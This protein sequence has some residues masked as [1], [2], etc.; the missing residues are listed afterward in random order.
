MALLLEEGTDKL[1][2]SGISP[3]PDDTGKDGNGVQGLVFAKGLETREKNFEAAPTDTVESQ[4]PRG[5]AQ[6]LAADGRGGKKK[7]RGSGKEERRGGK[8]EGRGGK[9]VTVREVEKSL[10]EKAEKKKRVKRHASEK[11]VQDDSVKGKRARREAQQPAAQ[12]V[13]AVDDCSA[14]PCE[15]WVRAVGNC[16]L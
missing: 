11:R 5:S 4:L 8:E 13:D 15:S 10:R 3:S 7:E 14:K 9:E 1:I 2:F 12:P 6:R 16:G